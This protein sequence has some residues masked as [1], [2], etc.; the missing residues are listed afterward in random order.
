VNAAAAIEALLFDLGGVVM[1][2]DWEPMFASWA[3]DS[4]VDA[5]ALRARFRFDEP[6]ERHECGA[7]DAHAYYDSLRPM[8]GIAL[9]DARLEAGWNAIF[10]E[11]IAPTVRLLES[12]EGRIPLYA[13]SNTNV[14]HHRVWSRKF[15]RALRPF[16]R[17]F[18]S[19]E[20]GL[21][22]PECEA[23]HAIAREVRVDPSR[24][25]FFDDTRQNVEG[26]LAAG[27]PAVH[28]RS[29]QDVEDALRRYSI[30]P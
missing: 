5:A 21:R 4:G 23:F 18:V 24:L 8:L 2:L 7:I 16:A 17:I 13:F 3:R 11:P 30:R 29:P 15:E 25:L 20:L 6:Y 26:A 22:K 19:C 27:L 9:D 10:T 12:L 14:T 28:V 1:G